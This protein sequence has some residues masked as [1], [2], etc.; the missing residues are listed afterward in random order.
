M[1]LIRLKEILDIEQCKLV[2]KIHNN[3]QKCNINIEF[4]FDV[5]SYQTRSHNT[6][7]QIYTRTNIGLNNSIVD[8]I[9]TFNN[10]AQFIKG[11]NNY[12]SFVRT[13][14]VYVNVN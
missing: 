14:K 4:L 7:Y 11:L 1:K 6:I 5:H 2:Y 12:K 13:L 3:Q 10:L 8:A 9:K